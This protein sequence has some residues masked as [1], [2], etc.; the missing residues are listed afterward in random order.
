MGNW[1]IY[2]GRSCPVSVDGQVMDLVTAKRKCNADKK[3]RAIQCAVGANNEHHMCTM[4]VFGNPL[5]ADAHA[6]CYVMQWKKFSGQSCQAYAN[7]DN[8]ARDLA[9]SKVA[10]RSNETLTLTLTLP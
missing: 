3:C 2:T 1:G 4:R 7:G 10:C 8:K 6:V 9:A 5:P